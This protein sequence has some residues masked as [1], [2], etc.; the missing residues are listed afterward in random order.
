[1][2]ETD[3]CCDF[4][5]VNDQRKDICHVDGARTNVGPCPERVEGLSKI[6]GRFHARKNTAVMLLDDLVL[7]DARH[8]DSEAEA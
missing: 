6:E 5:P 3:W 2:G 7:W 1:M 8:P 4:K